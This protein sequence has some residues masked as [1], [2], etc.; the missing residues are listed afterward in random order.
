MLLTAAAE[1]TAAVWGD[2]P[3]RVFVEADNI[4]AVSVEVP[5]KVVA[6]IRHGID[7]GD[8]IV[9]LVGD[10]LAVRDG[11]VPDLDALAAHVADAEERAAPL[12]SQWPG[13]LEALREEASRLT[14]LDTARPAAD[15]FEHLADGLNATRVLYVEAMLDRHPPG[16]YDDD[17]AADQARMQQWHENWIADTAT[18]L[19]AWRGDAT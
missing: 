3:E 15:L 5:T 11:W 6:G 17:E 12:E 13:T 9:S 8:V 10:A 14:S 1:A 4:E 2:E 18:R 16:P 7:P 19:A